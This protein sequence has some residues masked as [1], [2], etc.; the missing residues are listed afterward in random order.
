M[1]L[2][3]LL[4]QEMVAAKNEKELKPFLKKNNLLIRNS[5]NRWAWNYVSVI[6]E[7]SLSDQYRVD[8]LILSADSGSWGAVFVELKSHKLKLFNKNGTPSKS[9]NIGLR[10]LDDWERWIKNNERIFREKLSS[11]F[12]LHKVPAY[13]SNASIHTFACTEILDFKTS[14]DFKYALVIGRR[15][16][17]DREDQGRRYS[18]RIKGRE[19]STYD[20]L[21][22]VAMKIDSTTYETT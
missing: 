8:F 18:F 15:Y 13:C 7:Y 21:L 14:I 17:L 9:L 2:R 3:N 4:E 11:Y 22:D 16:C 5:F 20:R 19:I 10:Q 12:E 1:N 6:P